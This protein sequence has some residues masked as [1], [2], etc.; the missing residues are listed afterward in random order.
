MLRVPCARFSSIILVYSV[1]YLVYNLAIFESVPVFHLNF[2]N[3]STID[4]WN[5]SAVNKTTNYI[6]RIRRRRKKNFKCIA[7]DTHK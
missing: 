4:Y 3:I 2:L 7:K 6:N 1:K 5:K